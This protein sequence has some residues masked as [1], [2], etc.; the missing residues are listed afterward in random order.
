MFLTAKDIRD[1]AERAKANGHAPK[2]CKV[3]WYEPCIHGDEA[4][5]EYEDGT[6][7]W[8]RH[9]LLT[10]MK[11]GKRAMTLADL[12]NKIKR[13]KD[14]RILE[15]WDSGLDGGTWIPAVYFSVAVNGKH[16]VIQTD[17]MIQMVAS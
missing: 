11:H 7:H 14:D 12:L 3:L 9:K 5:G 1:V 15:M 10:Q 6:A 8:Y 4:H 13:W 16:C 17:S 2:L